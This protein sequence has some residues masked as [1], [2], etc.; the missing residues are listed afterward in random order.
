MSRRLLIILVYLLILAFAGMS[1]L[2]AQAPDATSVNNR[3][4]ELKQQL[5]QVEK[6]IAEQQAILDAKQKES[7]SI[8][9]D[10]AILTAQ[11]SAAQLKIKAR[12][13][14][15]QT[16]GKDI[17]KKTA[18]ISNLSNKIDRERQS[19]GQLIRK[20]NE[21]DSFSLV[22]VMLGN[23]NL[24]DFF[25]DLD[26]V[27]TLKRT[28]DESVQEIKD[29]KSTTETEKQDLQAKQS[30]EIDARVSIESEQRKIQKS[31]A[32]KKSL[33]SVSKLQEKAYK[34]LLSE[35]QAEASKIRSALF[36]LRDTAAIPF[37]TALTYA[38]A[39]S[40]KT[41]VRPA[42][43]LAILTQETNLGENIGTCNR[44]GDPPEK[45]WKVIMKPDRDQAP[46]LRIT[47]AL[48]LDP[49]TMPLSCPWKGGWGGAMGPSQ[50]I[51]STWELYQSKIALAVNKTTPS[52]WEP[53][54]AFMAT[55]IY[56]D[57]LGAGNGGYTAERTAA[58]KYYA[59]SAWNKAANAFYGN[60]VMAKATN[61]QENM[62]DPLQ[63][64]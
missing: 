3:Q 38:N 9:R 27:N 4:E 21:I 62:I 57:E 25:V 55:A 39:A 34:L 47:A 5:A 10:V 11:I 53:Q 30:Q 29:N 50:F 6:E 8:Q 51:P 2:H 31:E 40:V 45:G 1:V 41:G 64:L 15:I 20:T 35:R 33:L 59:G 48:G 28:L 36:Q 49:N 19:L 14:T 42:F 44:P 32:E 24:S 7:A 46:Y 16:L 54:D 26:S 22:E 18:T 63:G 52:P 60:Q 37:G 58:L 56:L 61:I 43:L 17:T 13:L 23:K 12:N